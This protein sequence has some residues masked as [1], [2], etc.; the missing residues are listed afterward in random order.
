MNLKTDQS[1]LKDTLADARMQIF[2]SISHSISSKAYLLRMKIKIARDN[3]D[4]A[5]FAEDKRFITPPKSA[6]IHN[7]R[8]TEP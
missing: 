6:K 7:N 2:V 5:W 1:A 3:P 8:P 4:R